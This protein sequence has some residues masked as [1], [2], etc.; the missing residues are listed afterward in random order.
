LLP[1]ACA[2]FILVPPAVAY[3]AD[4]QYNYASG[5]NGVGGAWF[6]TNPDYARRAYNQVWHQSGKQWTVWYQDPVNNVY[7]SVSNT[8]NPTKCSSLSDK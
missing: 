8:N 4:V 7:C 1:V 2:L 5:V 6:T 3:A